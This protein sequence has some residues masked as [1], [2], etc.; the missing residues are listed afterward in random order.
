MKSY[1]KKHG[2]EIRVNTYVITNIN[3]L[4]TS[5]TAYLVIAFIFCLLTASVF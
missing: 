5:S 2:N 4:Q 3:K 1:S